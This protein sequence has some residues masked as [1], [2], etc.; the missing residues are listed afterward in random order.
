[1]ETTEKLSII[2]IANEAAKLSQSDIPTPY[3]AVLANHYNYGNGSGSTLVILPEKGLLW[4]YYGYGNN[5]AQKIEVV[6]RSGLN[7]PVNLG[8]N[9]IEVEPGDI[10]FY[11]LANPATDRIILDYQYSV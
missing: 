11:V 9:Y 4:I 8:E 10:L 2:E 3:W 1:M 5:P 7:T 6:H